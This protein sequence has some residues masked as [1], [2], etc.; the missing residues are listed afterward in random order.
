MFTGHPVG[1][2]KKQFALTVGYLRQFGVF[3]VDLIVGENLTNA[4]RLRLPASISEEMQK[5]W[6]DHIVE[7]ARIGPLLNQPLTRHYP[8]NIV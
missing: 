6:F 3:H 4:L 2:I 5:Q 7:L 1:E 8:V